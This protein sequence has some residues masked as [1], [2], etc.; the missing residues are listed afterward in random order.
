MRKPG[1]GARLRTLAVRAVVVAGAYLA[2]ALA[3]LSVVLVLRV[4]LSPDPLRAVLGFYFISALAAGLEPATVK[5]AVLSSGRAPQNLAGV[6]AAG[7]VKGVAAGPILAL[8]W[9]LADPHTAVS[10]LMLS[11]LSAVAG[12]WATDLRVVL[13]VRGRHAAAVWLKQ[14]SLAGGFVLLALMVGAGIPLVWA[15]LVSSL[16]RLLPPAL[17]TLGSYRRCW[18][19]GGL[20][21]DPRWPA[22]AAISAVAA[23][24]GSLDRVFALRYLA[25]STFAGYLIVYELFSRFWLIPYLV[26]PVLFARLAAGGDSRALI[27]RAGFATA[28]LGVLFVCAVAS[29][30]FSGLAGAAGLLGISFLPPVIAFAAAVALGALTQLRI[31]QMQGSGAVRRALLVTAFGALVSGAAFYAGVRA[32]GLPGLYWAWLVKSV[33]EFAAATAWS[34]DVRRA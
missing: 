7:A 11:P 1:W 33:I 32:M 24:G 13:D 4:R 22:L 23:A 29:A 5:A 8:V 10:M 16:A 17:I 34:P 18:R 19:V 9:W 30:A 27:S 2:T 14:G 12:F 20:L 15:A 25:A 31:A 6:L 3:V 26:A 28:T 21:R